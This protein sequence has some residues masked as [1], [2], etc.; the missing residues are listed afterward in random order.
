MARTDCL[1][2]GIGGGVPCFEA[3]V[4]AD[5]QSRIFAAV[6]VC[7]KIAR[8]TDGGE[9]FEALD[10]PPLPS[11][12]RP[13]T[14]VPGDCTLQIGPDRSLWFTA[15]YFQD[16]PVHPPRVSNHYGIQVARRD[17]GG[18]SWAVN[19]YLSPTTNPPTPGTFPDRQWLSFGSGDRVYLTFY[20]VDLERSWIAVSDDRGQTFGPFQPTAPQDNHGN[21]VATG[22]GTIHI[23]WYDEESDTYRTLVSTSHDGGQTFQTRTVHEWDGDGDQWWPDLEQ[24]PAGELYVAWRGKEQR[25][26]LAR[27]T[28]DGWTDPITV[29][30]EDPNATEA[31]PGLEAHDGLA[32][33]VWYRGAGEDR[34][35]YLL[36]R[37]PVDAWNES[38][39]AVHTLDRFNASTSVTHF[40]DMA[41]TPSGEAV[42]AWTDPGRGLLVAREI[43][44]IPSYG[45]GHD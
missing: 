40:A 27:T 31:G 21:P 20:G 34:Q 25:V 44:G 15:Y 26:Q 23:P 8:S 6:S 32:D 36:A 39:V 35:A 16:R 5:P 10:L 22:N 9:A 11:T 1:G 14:T 7:Q 28:G 45:A 3:S 37:I 43:V 4:A 42:F 38:A 2:E 29:N 24:G 19:T 13:T 18:E 33:V 41:A 30:P 12:A 17:D